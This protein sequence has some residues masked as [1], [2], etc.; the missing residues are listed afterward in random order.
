MHRGTPV[1]GL[2]PQLLGGELHRIRRI[3]D[4]S[5]AVRLE[6]RQVGRTVHPC[7]HASLALDVARGARVPERMPFPNTDPIAG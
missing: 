7:H 6:V 3:E 4:V 1:T 5:P 2:A